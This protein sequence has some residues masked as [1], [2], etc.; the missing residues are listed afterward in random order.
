MLRRSLK[1]AHRYTQF[2]PTENG[3]YSDQELTDAKKE[4]FKKKSDWYLTDR[5]RAVQSA[6]DLA[7]DRSIKL[8]FNDSSFAFRSKKTRELIRASLCFRLFSVEHLVDNNMYYMNMFKRTFGEGLFNMAM[9]MTVYGQFVAGED[10]DR[11]KPLV[12]RMDE[13][14]VGSILDYAVEEDLDKPKATQMEMD[15][16]VPEEETY[17]KIERVSDPLPFRKSSSFQY[18]P[19]QKFADRRVGVVSARTYFYEDEEQCDKNMENFLYC[20]EAAGGASKHGFAAIKLTAL[21]RPQFLLQFSEALMSSRELFEQLSGAHTTSDGETTAK[22]VLEMGFDEQ[23]FFDKA[24]R[25]GVAVSREEIIQQFTFMMEESDG[26]VDMLDWNNLLDENKKIA[27][28]FTVKDEN[29]NFTN[30][31][32]QL[33][34][35]E[36]A[37]M[38]RMLERIDILANAAKENGVRLMIDA[39]QTYFQPAISR[40]TMEMMRKFNTESPIIFNTYQ[41][42]LKQGFNNFVI[43]VE[44]A[45]R[46]GFFFGAKIVRGAYADQ[47]RARADELG[48]PDPIQVDYEATGRC[49]HRVMDVGLEFI[50][51]HGTVNLMIAS[52]NIDSIK[53]AIS[54]MDSLNIQRDSGEVF[55]GQLLGMCDQVT[56]PLGQAGYSVYKYVPFGPVNEVLPYLSRRAQENRS[57]LDGVKNERKMLFREIARRL[58]RGNVK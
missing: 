11:I 16:C 29:G 37:Q 1:A 49:Y 48:Y 33:T 50:H 41:C 6:H 7:P 36:E 43:D 20:I 10:K 30:L 17:Q 53:Y 22:S 2:K 9:K 40:L 18:Q 27:D 55:F 28:I 12:R 31:M 25:M 13:V 51:T 45:R 23:R 54:R 46:E 38:K 52:H 14:G 24:G 21:G 39:E 47:E 4:K 44:Q 57:L 15:S 56:F 42:Y 32:K 34:E 8:T 35:D 19:Q 5:A 3:L 26:Y 58:A